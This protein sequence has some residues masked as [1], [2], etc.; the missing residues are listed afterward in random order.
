MEFGT[1]QSGG[2]ARLL[3]YSDRKCPEFKL[4]FKPSRRRYNGDCC[5]VLPQTYV[6]CANVKTYRRR[7]FQKPGSIFHGNPSDGICLL[8]HRMRN[9]G[10][11][12]AGD[13]EEA[14]RDGA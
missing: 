4:V 5:M 3:N 14:Q 9:D 6:V 1:N 2:R 13:E 10:L 8:L 12:T 7:R 11:R